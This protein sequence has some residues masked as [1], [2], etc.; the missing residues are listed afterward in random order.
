MEAVIYFV[1]ADIIICTIVDSWFVWENWFLFV[2]LCFNARFDSDE[3][4]FGPILSAIY[5][6]CKLNKP[7]Q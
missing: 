3:K 6:P 7:Y 2:R 4:S 5:C 1:N